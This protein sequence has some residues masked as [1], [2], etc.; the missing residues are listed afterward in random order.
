MLAVKANLSSTM[1]DKLARAVL[2]LTG[3]LTQLTELTQS[4]ELEKHS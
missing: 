3:A 1:I 2:R 4:Y